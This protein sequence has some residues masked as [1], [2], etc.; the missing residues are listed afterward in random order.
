[1]RECKISESSCVRCELCLM[2]EDDNLSSTFLISIPK[3][4]SSSLICEMFKAI[5]FGVCVTVHI[6]IKKVESDEKAEKI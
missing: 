2:N 4:L 3:S 5:I 6:I 1:M